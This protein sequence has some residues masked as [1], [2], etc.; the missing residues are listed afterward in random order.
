MRLWRHQFRV[1]QLL[2]WRSRELAFFTFLLPIVFLVLLGSAYG[3]NEVD[4]ISGYEFLLAGMLG[5]GAASTTFAGLG[6]ILVLRRESGTLKR[7][8][9]TPLPS[10]TYLAALFSSFVFVYFVE[11]AILIVL[12][13]TI[14]DVAV[15][16]RL[17]SLVLVLFDRSGVVH[18]ARR[19]RLHARAHGGGRVGR[20]QRD[21]P[22]GRL[23]RRRLLLDGRV[24]A[25]AAVDRRRPAALA[26]HRS[27]SRRRRRRTSTSGARRATSR[28]WPPGASWAP[29]WRPRALP[30]GA[31]GTLEPPAVYQV[32]CAASSSPDSSSPRSPRRPPGGAETQR[33]AR[34][35]A[36]RPAGRATAWTATV[37]RPPGGQATRRCR[38]GAHL[39]QRAHRADGEHGAGGQARL[40]P[41]ARRAALR[42]HVERR[43]PRERRPLQSALGQRRRHRRPSSRCFPPRTPLRAAAASATFC[44]STRSR[45]TARTSGSAA[46]VRACCAASTRPVA[47]P[48]R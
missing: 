41:G 30:L 33:H 16:S 36:R 10:R 7:L 28:S 43:G 25:G 13:R 12:A 6:I 20:D 40:V 29:S 4:G 45:S 14:F 27:R 37:D 1:E 42:G 9:A 31:A 46:A 39:P 17:L 34:R 35:T 19:R 22:A 26:L 5:Y 32:P 8:R 44:R 48:P 47:P 11:A 21:L 3:D 18:G 2:F 24:P 23:H 15:P 38:A